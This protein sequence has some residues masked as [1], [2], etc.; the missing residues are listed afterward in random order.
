MGLRDSMRG[1]GGQGS[2]QSRIIIKQG[3]MCT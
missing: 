3:T 2:D 1:N